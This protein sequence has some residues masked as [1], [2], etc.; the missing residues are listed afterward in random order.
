MHRLRATCLLMCLGFLQAACST[1]PGSA[2]SPYGT[3]V[4]AAEVTAAESLWARALAPLDTAALERLLAPSFALVGQDTTPREAWFGNLRSGRVTPDSVSIRDLVVTAMTADSA[5]ATLT[6]RWRPLTQG[7]R[8]ARAVEV[9]IQ[10]TWV[11]QD[12][13]WRVVLRVVQRGAPR[14]PSGDSRSLRD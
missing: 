8:I 2:P 7:R 4:A 14:T 9:H 13:R 12:G 11:R 3:A 5:V 1:R 6:F 10:D